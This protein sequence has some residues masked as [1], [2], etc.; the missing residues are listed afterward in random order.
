MRR[1]VQQD[2]QFR[3][4]LHD[5]Q[6]GS[7]HLQAGGVLAHEGLMDAHAAL[8]QAAVNL[9]V[10]D[11]QLFQ[12]RRA[13]AVDHH[14]QSVSGGHVQLGQGGV[15]QFQGNLVGA[16]QRAAP[17]AFFSNITFLYSVSL[18]ESR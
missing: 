2:L 6:A 4:E 3:V 18:P 15:Q 17:H 11:V 5:A 7:G 16:F 13:Q 12:G 14:G 1:V 10:Q 9:P 8:L